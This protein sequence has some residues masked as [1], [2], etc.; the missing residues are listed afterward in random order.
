[1][2]D[3]RAIA[4]QGFG[5]GAVQIALQGFGQAAQPAAGGWWPSGRRHWR[6]DE[7]EDEQQPEVAPLPAEPAPVVAKPRRA[8]PVVAGPTSADLISELAARSEAQRIHDAEV[9][10]ARIRA[11]RRRVALL[12]L[13]H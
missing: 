10:A 12:M 8:A 9:E 1:M 7:D 4:L 13:L 3:A 5:S 6:Y 11:K 2:I